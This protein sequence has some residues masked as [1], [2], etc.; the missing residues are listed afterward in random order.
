[1]VYRRSWLPGRLGRN[2]IT[3]LYIHAVS[4]SLRV[5]L[6]LGLSSVVADE[7]HL[8]MVEGGMYRTR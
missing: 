3:Y 1:M 2:L 8:I 4:K 5:T 6:S 7:I